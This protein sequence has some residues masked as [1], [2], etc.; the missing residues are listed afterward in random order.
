MKEKSPFS[1]VSMT[2][3]I[4]FVVEEV[5]PRHDDPLD[6]QLRALGDP[7][8]HPEGALGILPDGRLNGC[9]YKPFVLAYFQLIS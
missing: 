9:V 8:G 6:L 3:R 2:L 1:E 7:E 5:V 4:A